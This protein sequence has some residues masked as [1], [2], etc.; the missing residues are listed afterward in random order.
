MNRSAASVVIRFD[1]RRAHLALAVAA[2]RALPV[3]VGEEDDNVRMLFAHLSLRWY[4]GTE[5]AAWQVAA[6]ADFVR[7]P[8]IDL[9]TGL[10]PFRTG[11]LDNEAFSPLSHTTYY[12]RLRYAGYRVAMVGKH[13]LAQNDRFKG[14]LGSRPLTYAFGFTDPHETAGKMEAGKVDKPHCPYT[15]ALENPTRSACSPGSI[16][17]AGRPTS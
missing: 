11:A 14:C 2:G 16:R 3:I 8:A 10:Y 15:Q 5:A 13:D 4:D 1:P 17:H 6:G 9:A 7:T 12:Q